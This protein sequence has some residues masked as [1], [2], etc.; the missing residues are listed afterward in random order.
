MLI[1]PSTMSEPLFSAMVRNGSVAET[2]FVITCAG[3]YPSFV[4]ITYDWIVGVGVAKITNVSAPDAL[5]FAT[6]TD[7]GVVALRSYGC[8]VTICDACDRSPALKPRR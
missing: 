6:C 3:L 7:G 1:D 5:I 4:A 8:A 2:E